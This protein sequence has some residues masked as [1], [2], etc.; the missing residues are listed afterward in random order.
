MMIDHKGNT[1]ALS[2]IGFIKNGGTV[3]Q[4]NNKGESV[5]M[6]AP[7]GKITVAGNS[8]ANATTISFPFY[9]FCIS[10]TD[11][12]LLQ[13]QTG[14]MGGYNITALPA[15]GSAT[16]YIRNVSNGALSESFD[17]R[18]AVIKTATS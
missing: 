17:I 13:Q 4:P 2:G 7:A 16:I 5:T 18:F 15:N 11:I 12:I 10:S 6:H 1:L 3:I 9:N 8:I 14:T